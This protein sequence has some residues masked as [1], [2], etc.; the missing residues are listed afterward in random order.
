MAR[1]EIVPAEKSLARFFLLFSFSSPP[2]AIARKGTLYFWFGLLISLDYIATLTFWG[3]FLYRRHHEVR[4]C[5]RRYVIVARRLSEFCVGVASLTWILF[6]GRFHQWHR[7]R[8]NRCGPYLV[9]GISKI[10]SWKIFLFY[11]SMRVK[12][13]PWQLTVF[14][15]PQVVSSWKR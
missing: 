5:V 14:Q 12:E 8:R 13:L 3:F 4:T 2:L 11:L 6:R 7:K 1:V 9:H 10:D 15:R